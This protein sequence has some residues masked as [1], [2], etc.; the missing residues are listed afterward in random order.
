MKRKRSDGAGVVGDGKVGRG[1]IACYR[2]IGDGKVD[3]WK[4]GDGKA[5]DGDENVPMLE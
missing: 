1:G 2:K 4:R 3:D 5:G